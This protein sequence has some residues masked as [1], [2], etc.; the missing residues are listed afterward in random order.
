MTDKNRAMAQDGY[1]PLLKN[2]P[3]TQIKVPSAENQ[4]GYQPAKN[5]STQTKPPPK[6]P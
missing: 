1:Q 5:Q 2:S 4:R 6:K 3:Q